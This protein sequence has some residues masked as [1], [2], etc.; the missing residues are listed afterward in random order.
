MFRILADNFSDIDS[1]IDEEETEEEEESTRKK[2]RKGVAA[3]FKSRDSHLAGGEN[4]MFSMVS[5]EI[6][7][8]KDMFVIIFAPP[9][10]EIQYTMSEFALALSLDR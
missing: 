3:L 9:R 2:K 8:S 10:S 6:W 4:A 1:V 5:T 7:F